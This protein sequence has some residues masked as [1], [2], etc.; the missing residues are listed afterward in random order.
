MTHTRIGKSSVS[1]GLRSIIWRGIGNAVADGTD[2]RHT[3]M[4]TSCPRRTWPRQILHALSRLWLAPTSGTERGFRRRVGVARGGEAV[5]RTQARDFRQAHPRRRVRW[6]ELHGLLITTESAAVIALRV[7]KMPRLEIVVV[8]LKVLDLRPRRNNQAPRGKSH[9]DGLDD[10]GSDLVLNR[11]DEHVVSRLRW[12][13]HSGAPGAG[14][15]D[16]GHW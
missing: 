3:E 15:I 14:E 9:S 12:P 10:S 7:A 8:G 2:E 5:D 1:S 11:E 13:R 6:I 16:A 4:P